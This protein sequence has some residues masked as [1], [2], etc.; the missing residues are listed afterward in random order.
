M[1]GFAE[2][3]KFLFSFFLVLPAV[4]LLHELGHY[5]MARIFGG[6]VRVH[7]GTG[8]VLMKLGPLRIRKLYF[9]DGWCEYVS[10]REDHKLSKILVY[11][12]GAL[13]NLAA[14]LIINFLVFRG[15]FEANLYFYQF[16]Y[17]SFYYVFF[18]LMPMEQANGCPSDGLAALNTLKGINFEKHPAD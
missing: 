17:F 7:V 8:N 16:M 4:T 11:L 10:L 15:V 2:I 6:K 12:G 18:S 13:F 14:I 1:F 5:V 9:Y 3:A